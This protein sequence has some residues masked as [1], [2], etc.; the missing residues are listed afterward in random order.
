MSEIPQNKPLAGHTVI[1]FTHVLAGPAAGH[2]MGLL[3]ADVIKIESVGRG[4][5]MRHRSGT[6]PDRS[7]AGMSTAYLAQ[8]AQ[9]RSLAIDLNTMA[10]YEIICALLTKADVFIENHLPDTLK[11]LKLDWDRISKMNDQLIH[12][13]M[14]GY[15][16]TGPRAN[17]PA[18]DTNIQGVAGLMSVTGTEE[19]GPLRTG[20]PILDYGTGMAAAFA[21]M[22]ALYDRMRTGRG[23]FIDLSMLETAFFLMTSS[24]ADYKLTGNTPQ[25]R[26]NNANS[27]M[28][29]SGSYETRDGLLTLAISEQHQ[30]EALAR[31]LGREDWLAPETFGTKAARRKNRD[32][33]AKALADI[34]LEKT[35]EEWEA[36]LWPF[37]V[38][39]GKVRDIPEILEDPQVK[40]RGFLH[41]PNMGPPNDSPF[42]VSLPFMFDGAFFR[43]ETPPP[44]RGAHSKEILAEMGYSDAD[45]EKLIDNGCV[46]Q[47]T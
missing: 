36:Q 21:A 3:G 18:Y 47:A 42:N 35:A 24:L 31:G 16:Q 15:G 8:G 41:N 19:S 28:P 6:D 7:A 20:P 29:G 38:P 23:H 44:K 26:G 10:G 25:R 12:V 34:M 13:A 4:D 33:F 30:F 11:A 14:T 22:I 39:C 9:K 37:G 32:A 5:A 40:A 1:D 27:R 2:I 46:E 43:A 45:I 17:Q